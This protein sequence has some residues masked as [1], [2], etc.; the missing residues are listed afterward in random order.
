MKKSICII[1]MLCFCLVG[2]TVGQRSV[3]IF[4]EDNE[5]IYISR[6]GNDVYVWLYTYDVETCTWDI[7]QIKECEV[8][9]DRINVQI[10]G[11]RLF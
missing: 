8:A 4:L 11:T 9:L 7:K 6:W 3:D 5:S 10:G 2:F 1:L